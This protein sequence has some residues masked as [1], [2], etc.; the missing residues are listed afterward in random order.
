MRYCTHCIL[1]ET[2]PNIAFDAAGRCNAAT[3]EEKRAID[4]SARA[5]A[6]G[7][8]VAEAK[9]RGA[10][11]DCVIPVSGGKDS[12]WQVVT[13]LEHGLR[14]LAVT[15]R[16]PGRTPVGRR[17]LDNL[18]GLGV[19][20]ID[21]TINPRVERA[22]MRLALQRIGQPA[23]PMHM[24]LFAI[25]LTVAVRYRVPLV[26]FGENSAFEYGGAARLRAAHELSSE[27]LD[28]FGVT[29]GTRAED[30]IGAELSAGDLAPYRAPSATELQQ[31]GVRPIFLGSYF[32]WDPELTRRVAAAHGFAAEAAGPRTGLWNFA[33][34]DDEFIAVHHY[35]KWPKFGLT[36]LM[37]NLALEI[38]HGRL[39]RDEAIEI[40]RDR[41]DPTPHA[42]IAG[43][44]RYLDMTVDE[45]HR[46]AERFRDR[47]IWVR[48]DG[49][50]MIDGF[51]VSDWTWT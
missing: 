30:W 40:M 32:L 1:P 2:R 21:F 43:Y 44:C 31:A 27:W 8:L 26:V 48:R 20:H 4:W 28:R 13:C 14:P 18:I 5:D 35:L 17:N 9:A 22:F 10:S 39:G 46:I 51:I 50:W 37:D 24:A 3:L 25:P 42:D 12:T 36:R 29:G 33:D 47:E 34:I 15:W 7:R 45:F 41:G 19:D 11:W 49:V 23:T 6:F 16:T 38:R